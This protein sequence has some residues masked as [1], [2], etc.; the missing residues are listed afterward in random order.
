MELPRR[1]GL[2]P[3]A[4]QGGRGQGAGLRDAAVQER[5]RAGLG[6]ARVDDDVHAARDGRRDDRVGERGLPRG[7]GAGAGQVRD[8]GAL[9]EHPGRAAGDHRR[10]DGGQAGHAGGGPGVPRVPLRRGRAGNRGQALLPAATGQGGEQARR[11]LP[12][13]EPVHHRRGLRR[14][15]QGSA[16]ALRRRRH[17]R[18]D[19]P[20]EVMAADVVV[21]D[22]S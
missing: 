22:R 15:G 5:P 6:S 3:P 13:G 10:Q 16:Q 17:L 8:R 20:A 21:K 2:R 7:E 11:R 19:L 18:R 1:V 12:Q 14:L 9:G 4:E